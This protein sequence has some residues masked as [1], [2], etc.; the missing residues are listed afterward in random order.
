MRVGL[1]LAVVFSLCC[2]AHSA[3][4]VGKADS[5]FENGK[6][7]MNNIHGTVM[8]DPP[9][10]GKNNRTRLSVVNGSGFPLCYT[11][12]HG[13]TEFIEQL[14][15]GMKDGPP[16]ELTVTGGT[17]NVQQNYF[18]IIGQ[19]VEGKLQIQ[20]G[21]VNLLGGRKDDAIP[22]CE[23]KW[24]LLL[25]NALTGKGLVTVSGG[26]LKVE[27]GIEIGRGESTGILEISGTGRVICSGPILF[28]GG[29]AP[30]WIILGAGSG[31]F[32]QNSNAELLFLGDSNQ[33]WFSFKKGSRG[34]ISLYGHDKLAFEHL[35]AEG[36]IRIDSRPTTPDHFA[37]S[38]VGNQGEYTLAP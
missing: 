27:G 6:N 15:I 9:Q 17:L 23:T 33:G 20:S 29:N 18:A 30:K 7:W 14:L 16:G 38:K 2:S 8:P 36:R 4:W 25:G 24:S 5:N 26:E 3:E 19:T 11:A 13:A 1:P 34:K 28:T 31:V 21:T 22:G 12:T 10:A 35:V 37:Y 32:E